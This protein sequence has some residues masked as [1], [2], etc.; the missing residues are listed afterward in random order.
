MVVTR[1]RQGA[2]GARYKSEG[3][4][5]TGIVY[6]QVN[7]RSKHVR[8]FKDVP[9]VAYPINQAQ[10][11]KE[12]STTNHGAKDL[13]FSLEH[14]IPSSASPLGCFSVG[15]APIQAQ[16]VSVKSK[17]VLACSRALFTPVKDT[18]GSESIPKSS[19]LASISNR[20]NDTSEQSFLFTVSTRNEVGDKFEGDAL[21]NSSG[22]ERRINDQGEKF[23]DSP[24]SSHGGESS[25][26]APTSDGLIQGE[27]FSAGLSKNNDMEEDSSDPAKL[28]ATQCV[29]REAMGE[30]DEGER[31]I[32]HMC[33]EHLPRVLLNPIA[34]VRP[35]RGDVEADGMEFEGGGEN[36]T[37]C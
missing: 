37:S 19:I 20:S 36:P 25:D 13:G 18:E 35:T 17:K 2:R 34:E 3:S 1:K 6:R 7:T 30:K 4:G 15:S 31:A 21:R 29:Y 14:D 28:K 26:R 5:G 32:S 10:S 23:L 12:L 9:D 33:Q 22:D 8:D 11:S 27:V 24:F 16:N